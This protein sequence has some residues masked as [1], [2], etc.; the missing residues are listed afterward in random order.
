MTQ[1]HLVKQGIRR[2]IN[3][4]Q[5]LLLL[6][7]FRFSDH[8]YNRQ[9]FYKQCNNNKNLKK[10]VLTARAVKKNFKII[11]ITDNKEKAR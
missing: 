11:K 5:S 10:G 8:P 2:I 1:I 9:Q 4:K 7:K 6:V 3:D